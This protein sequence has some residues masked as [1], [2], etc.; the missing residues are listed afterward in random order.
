MKEDYLTRRKLVK[1]FNYIKKK[2]CKITVTDDQDCSFEEMQRCDVYTG[3]V[4]DFSVSAF[5]DAEIRLLIQ[6]DTGGAE[7]W[8]A[9]SYYVH[10]FK[11]FDY[12][13]YLHDNGDGTYSEFT[14]EFK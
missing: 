9:N 11:M 6:F 1:L 8:L 12:I 7:I 4:E 13:R 5:E 3:V 10:T 14:I 2:G